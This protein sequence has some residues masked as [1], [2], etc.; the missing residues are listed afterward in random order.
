MAEEAKQVFPVAKKSRSRIRKRARGFS[1]GLE[2]PEARR[3]ECERNRIIMRFYRMESAKNMRNRFRKRLESSRIARAFSLLYAMHNIL[4]KREKHADKVTF[5]KEH[6][7]VTITFAC[8]QTVFGGH[9]LFFCSKT[10]RAASVKNR[11]RTSNY[12]QLCISGESICCI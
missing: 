7:C 6:Y 2:K 11:E 1:F 4:S 5:L 9:E 12:G 10:R 3:T 8:L